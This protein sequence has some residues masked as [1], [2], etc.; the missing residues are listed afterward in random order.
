[1]A[2]DNSA[3]DYFLQNNPHKPENNKPVSNAEKRIPAE[4]PETVRVPNI[5]MKVTPPK[6]GSASKVFIAALSALLVFFCVIY[7]RVETQ[8]VSTDC[9]T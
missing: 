5:A 6:R 1:M 8:D 4:E 9:C 2:A 7:G 3:Y